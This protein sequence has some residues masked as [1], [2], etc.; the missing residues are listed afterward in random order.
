MPLYTRFNYDDCHKGCIL[1]TTVVVVSGCLQFKA[2]CA[3]H[4]KRQ[5]SHPRSVFMAHQQ[6]FID[7]FDGEDEYDR[8]EDGKKDDYHTN[9]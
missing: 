8:Y 9:D 2:K 3:V 7:K 5:I 1:A 4:I 6:Y